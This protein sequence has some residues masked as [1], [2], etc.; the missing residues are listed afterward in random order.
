M[1][2]SE[3]EDDDS[4][5]VSGN[6]GNHSNMYVMLQTTTITSGRCYVIKNLSPATTYGCSIQVS[7]DSWCAANQNFKPAKLLEDTTD[8]YIVTTAGT[9]I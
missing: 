5:Q 4:P 1:R 7:Y 2:W 3:D 9:T 6:Y 8:I